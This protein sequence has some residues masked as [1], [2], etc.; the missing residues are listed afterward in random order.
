MQ[1]ILKWA[2]IHMQD[3]LQERQHKNY[4]TQK[5]DPTASHN[6]Q[7]Y[8]WHTCALHNNT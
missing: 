3:W 5:F 2:Q 7:Y 8:D 6:I 1:T 4:G